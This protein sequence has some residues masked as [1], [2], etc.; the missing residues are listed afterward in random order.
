MIS[1]GQAS[2]YNFSRTMRHLFAVG[3]KRDSLALRE[4]L[5]KKYGAKNESVALYHSGRSALSAALMMV[6]K[7]G[8]KVIIPGLTCIAVVRAVKAAGMEP[9]FV[10]ITAENLEYD[11][12][13]LDK[14]G[15]AC[16]NGIIVVQNTL[17]L[18]WDVLKIE[19]IAKKYHL[20][21]VEDLAHSAGRSYLDG[22]EVG[23]IGK[24]VALS[25][26]KG[27]AI[28]T[29]NGGAVVLRNGKNVEQPKKLPKLSER[30]RD[31]WYPV[32][33]GTCRG[34]W[35][36]GIGKVMM[37]GFVKLRFVKRS[38]DTELD[39]NVRLTGWQ[40][41]L[42]LGQLGNL[43]NGPLREFRLV[44][45][46]KELLSKLNKAGY[47]FCEIWYDTPVS[48]ARYSAEANFPVE[49]CPTTV[50]IAEKIIN[51]PTWY[52]ERK[53]AKARGIIAQYEIGGKK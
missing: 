45:Q 12:K 27:K 26:G 41:K 20:T 4:A 9:V 33:A 46:R 35:R 47:N 28:D 5:A 14:V 42:A 16:Y 48:P 8:S 21:I 30:A 17:G 44:E 51:L 39:L 22:R 52:P 23:T 43:S 2:N 34:L 18:P 6:G 15:K 24:A 49:E 11:Y 32:L 7:K 25:F 40:A 10:D 19:K 36:T 37:V 29:I 50:R 1:L 53:I 31:R 3:G 38:A 13:M